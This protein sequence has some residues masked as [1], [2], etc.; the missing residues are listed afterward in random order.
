[1]AGDPVAQIE[2][3]RRSLLLVGALA[4]ALASAQPNDDADRLA[5]AFANAGLSTKVPSGVACAGGDR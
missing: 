3:M 4:L 2:T 1:M 5:R